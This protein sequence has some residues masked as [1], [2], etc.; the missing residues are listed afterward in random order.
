MTTALIPSIAAREVV[1]SAM[2]LVV[3]V[4]EGSEG[5][6]NQLAAALVREFGIGSLLAL[7]IWFVYA[8]QCISTF[9]VLKRESNTLKWP[10][11][12]VGYTL[13]LAYFFA[14]VTRMIFISF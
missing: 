3:S 10:L 4:K 8:P 7:L 6:E 5:F 14:W 13:A 2:S 9:A 11:F 12:M 1:V